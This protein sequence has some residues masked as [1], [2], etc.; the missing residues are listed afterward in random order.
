MIGVTHEG[1]MDWNE[2]ELITLGTEIPFRIGSEQL[3]VVQ[4]KGNPRY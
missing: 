2:N 4:G 1:Q 3:I